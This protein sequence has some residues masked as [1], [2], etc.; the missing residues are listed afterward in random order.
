GMCSY[1]LIGFWI[2]QPAMPNAYPFFICYLCVSLLFVG[3]VA[4][5]A[6][7]PLHVWLLDAMEGSTPISPL[8]QV[9]TMRDLAYST[10]SQLGYMMLALGMGT[11]RATL[12]HL[13]TYAYSKALLFL[14]FGLIIHSMEVIGRYSP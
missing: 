13:I 14:V 5:S 9:A 1:L 6:Q 2:I 7:F 8:I 10:M 3:A 11:Y 4:K 12:F